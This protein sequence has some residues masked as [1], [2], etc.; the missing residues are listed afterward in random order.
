[1][2]VTGFSL[3]HI[4]QS[5]P[6]LTRRPRSQKAGPLKLEIDKGTCCILTEH[7]QNQHH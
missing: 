6:L 1:M 5:H 2:P 4:S 3:K 7:N